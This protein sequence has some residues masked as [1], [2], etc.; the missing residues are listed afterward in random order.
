MSSYDEVLEKNALRQAVPRS[1][2]DRFFFPEFVCGVGMISYT[3]SPSVPHS[4]FDA[5]CFFLVE[6]HVMEL[7]DPRRSGGRHNTHSQLF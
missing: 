1:D 3:A 7:P 6:G 5:L 2:Q 4:S